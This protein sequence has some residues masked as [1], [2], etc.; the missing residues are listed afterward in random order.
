MNFI[1][2]PNTPDEIKAYPFKTAPFAH[3]MRGLIRSYKAPHFA[4]TWEPRC[5]KTKPTLDTAGLA[6]LRK[7]ITGLGIVAPKGVD[8]N[9][10]EDEIPLHLS[11]IVPRMCLLYRSNDVGRV[12]WKNAYKDL[13]K[14]DGLAILAINVDSTSRANG[15]T[16]LQ[17]FMDAR[18]TLLAFDES[19]DGKTPNSARTKALYHL[20][21]RAKA[22]RIL[23][24]TPAAESPLELF[25]QY[26]FL[27][28][29]ITGFS[30]FTAFKARYAVYETAHAYNKATGGTQEYEKLV[31]YAHLDELMAAVA[32]FTD[33]VQRADVFD[34][35]AKVYQKER[36]QL[37]PEQLR[38][39]NEL[40]ET[41][42]TELMSGAYIT[43]ANVLVRYLRLQ[44]V[45]SNRFPSERFTL[46]LACSGN[47]CATCDDAGVIENKNR[48]EGHVIDAT[49]NPRIDALNRVI[50]TS[51][52]RS[53]PTIVWCRFKTEAADIMAL[54]RDHNRK[55]MR[56]DGSCTDDEK[57]TA[58]RAYQAGD[59]D[60]I[61]GSA[62]AGGRGITLSKCELMV[63]FSNYFALRL[64]LQ[65]EDRGEAPGKKEGTDIVD[66]VAEGTIDEDLITGLRAKKS[67]S[68][69][70]MGDTVRQW[71]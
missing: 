55:V 7:S 66:L 58:K 17:K 46:C 71:L 67:L 14:F 6:F 41:Y 23:D 18:R 61:V 43:A 51:R 44:Q 19:A 4:L 59:I 1:L 36:Y 38:V 57:F 39:Y 16:A 52:A 54:A 12:W 11:D 31:S 21:K 22:K 15:R 35:P 50:G 65:S 40:R 24:G 26:R 32:P 68:D 60:F 69:M 27:D 20:S 56:Y 2:P 37:S 70:I 63:Y 29:A 25:A 3:Q 48:D 5:G 64:R 42:R 45:L 30:N 53:Q 49:H 34:M 47:G 33:R 10:L 28:P 62:P 13:L 9:W 8:R